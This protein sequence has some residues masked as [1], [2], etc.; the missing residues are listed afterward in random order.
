MDC[1]A[2]NLLNL[3][4]KSLMDELKKLHTIMTLYE[5]SSFKR[6]KRLSW[7]HMSQGNECP[8]GLT[9]ITLNKVLV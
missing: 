8:I 5:L 4:A 7:D 6:K 2:V 3:K 1:F 9:S